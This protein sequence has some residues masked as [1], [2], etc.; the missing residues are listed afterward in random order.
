ETEPM[1]PCGIGQMMA[2]PQVTG[3]LPSGDT[4]APRV[5]ETFSFLCVG[6]N[7]R[8]QQ[9]YE[10]STTTPM[11]RHLLSMQM[12]ERL[13]TAKPDLRTLRQR[14][15]VDFYCHVSRQPRHFNGRTCGWG[16]LA[17]LSVYFIHLSE[18]SHV[19]EKHCG[20]HHFFPATAC[21]LKNGGQIFQDLLCLLLNA[22][23][24]QI[25]GSWIK[26]NLAG[27]KDKSIGLDGLG[28]GANCLGRVGSGD[29][30][31]GE[32]HQCLLFFSTGKDT[33][34]SGANQA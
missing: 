11:H 25:S 30:I 32:T 1:V 24:N 15:Y 20:F 2:S 10:K 17:E 12:N 22:S 13:C 28:V 21:G 14:N 4:A 33:R 5:N 9:E 23:C 8:Q 19:L 16:S 31:A 29:Y 34:E 3:P 6:S 26:G 27:D 7:S 18:L